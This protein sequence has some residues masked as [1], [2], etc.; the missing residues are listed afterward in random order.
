MSGTAEEKSRVEV[1]V[2]V[3]VSVTSTRAVLVTRERT[4]SVVVLFAR[5]WS[6]S[7]TSPKPCSEPRNGPTHLNL[8]VVVAVVSRTRLVTVTDGYSVLRTT[9]TGSTDR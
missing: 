6:T 8:V 4:S 5:P 3:D 1:V 7:P 9:V 2:M